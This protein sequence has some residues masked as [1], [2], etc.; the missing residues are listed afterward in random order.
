MIGDYVKTVW[1][2]GDVL[3]KEPLNNNEDKTGELDLELEGHLSS[4]ALYK[5]NLDFMLARD[6][7]RII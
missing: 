3:L 7:R 2:T 1:N 4:Y 5:E 6:L